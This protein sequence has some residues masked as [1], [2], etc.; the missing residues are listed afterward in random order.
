M[1][2]ILAYTFDNLA[3][4]IARGLW[5]G[6]DANKVSL[7]QEPRYHYDLWRKKNS[8]FSRMTSCPEWLCASTGK[9]HPLRIV[10]MQ[11]LYLKI[12]AVQA[13]HLRIFFWMEVVWEKIITPHPLNAQLEIELAKSFLLEYRSY[14]GHSLNVQHHYLRYHRE[15]YPLEDI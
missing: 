9:L 2:Q 11:V 15:T 13:E 3:A 6:K 14:K 10:F 12:W 4:E 7:N 5:V 8:S 1:K